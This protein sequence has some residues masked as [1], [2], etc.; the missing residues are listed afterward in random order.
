LAIQQKAKSDQ[1]A[2]DGQKD[3]TQFSFDA[4]RARGGRG[5]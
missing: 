5:C 2:K 3:E 1:D 4:P